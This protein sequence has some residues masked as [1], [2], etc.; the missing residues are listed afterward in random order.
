MIY[1]QLKDSTS[2]NFVL[3]QKE[4][5]REVKRNVTYYNLN[6]VYESLGKKSD[7]II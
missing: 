6:V 7:D 3:V 5:N 2:T 4:G 1:N